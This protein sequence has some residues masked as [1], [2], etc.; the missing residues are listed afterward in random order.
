MEESSR[1]VEISQGTRKVMEA[2]ADTIIPGGD[3][4][5][6]GALDMDLVDRFLEFLGQFPPA[7]RWFAVFCWM[8]EFCPLWSGRLVRFSGLSFEERTRILES[9]ENSRFFFRRG[10]LII[11]KSIFLATFYNNRE[12]WPLLGYKEGCLSEPPNPIED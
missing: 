9:W 3:D 1:P 4:G 7:P 10:A 6:P 12:V 5:R 2:L 8:W 11:F